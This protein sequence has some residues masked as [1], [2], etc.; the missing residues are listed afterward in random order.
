MREYSIEWE[1]AQVTE[2]LKRVGDTVLPPTAQGAGWSLGCD[3]DFLERF[4]RHWLDRYDW[5]TALAGLK[6]WPQF[7]AEIDGIDIHF[8]HVVGE[9]QGRR[10]LLL[11]HGWPGSHYEFFQLIEKLAWPSRSG[12]DAADA[13]GVIIPSL[14]GYGYSG[15]PTTPVGPRYIAGLWN[16]LMTE[17]LGYPSYLAQGGDWGSLVTAWLGVDHV[18]AVKSIH[19]NM[20]PILNPDEQSEEERAFMASVREARNMMS[21][22]ST[23]QMMK[24]QSLALAAADNPLGI[25]AWI[26]ERFHDWR[27]RSEGDVDA[28]FGMDHLVTNIMI[29][30]MSGSFAT[31]LWLY[32]GITHE[33]LAGLQSVRVLAPTAFAIFPN[34]AL[35]PSPPRSMVERSFPI[36]RWTSPDR[37]GH[38]AAMEQPDVFLAD[39]R[40]WGREIWP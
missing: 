37:G 40:E 31:S 1:E 8:V 29:Y 38:F 16:R 9:A 26:L 34:D 10:P 23:L 4:R 6:A 22:Y 39:V 35:Q 2:V 28:I 13:F 20:V 32:N 25:A 7:K 5:R 11:T 14:P 12:G 18:P 24:P 15:R 30:V 19:L 36:A 27:D 33:D 3:V 17:V 21:G